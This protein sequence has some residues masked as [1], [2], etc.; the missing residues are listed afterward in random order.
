MK[1]TLQTLTLLLLVA[2][3]LF[4][5]NYLKPTEVL[6]SGTIETPNTTA[7]VEVYFD[8]YGV[9]HIFAENDDDMFFVAGYLGAR[10]RLF[11]MAF[12]KYTYKGQLSKVVNDTLFAENPGV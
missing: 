11:Q 3:V 4:V 10:D 5:K 8:G 6:Y 9:P 7:P 12:M 2:G 1:K